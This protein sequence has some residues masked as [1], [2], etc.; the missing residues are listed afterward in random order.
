MVLIHYKDM[1]E[2]TYLKRLQIVLKEL[3]AKCV[4]DIYCRLH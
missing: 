2:H 3:C 1:V 4:A